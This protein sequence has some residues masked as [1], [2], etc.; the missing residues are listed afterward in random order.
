M[1]NFTSMSQIMMKL[2][3]LSL[4]LYIQDLPPSTRTRPRNSKFVQVCIKHFPPFQAKDTKEV[5]K[6][7]QRINDLYDTRIAIW[8][9]TNL[10]SAVDRLLGKYPNPD[11]FT[12]Q[13]ILDG[14][15]ICLKCNA[16]R[17]QPADGKWRFYNHN[18]AQRDIN[19]HACEYVNCFMGDLDEH[20]VHDTVPVP[21]PLI[22]SLLPND[23]QSDNK[24]LDFTRYRDDRINLLL[25]P[26]HKKLFYLR[27]NR[28]NQSIKWTKPDWTEQNDFGLKADYLDLLITLENGFIE[29]EDNS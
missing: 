15:D 8:D 24:D 13:C 10:Y 29:V 27:L 18:R 5:C 28:A 17:Y 20:I 2:L 16:C 7:I 4:N 26:S 6:T 22:N 25:D 12:K 23:Q 9:V 19:C 11:G 14:M 3:Q 21:V 1:M